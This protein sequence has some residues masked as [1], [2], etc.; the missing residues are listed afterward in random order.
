ML[1]VIASLL[2][3]LL[4]VVLGFRVFAPGTLPSARAGAWREQNSAGAVTTAA[5]EATMAF[6][7]VDYRD[8]AP[9]VQRMLALSTGPFRAQYKES[10]GNLTATAVKGKAISSGIVRVIGIDRIGATSAV[11]HVGA[12]GS[13]SNVAIQQAEQAGKAA[14][15]QRAYRLRLTF[16]RV[17]SSWL[18]SELQ[19]V[20]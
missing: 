2:A 5:R 3:A 12:D 1:V 10:A 9:R 16:T 17:G 7:D 13:V 20:S 14:Q 6:L 4:L 11:V 19:F 18:L 8:M 15:N